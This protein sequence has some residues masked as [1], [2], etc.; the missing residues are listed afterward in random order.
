MGDPSPLSAVIL[1][2]Y[3]LKSALGLD[4]MPDAHLSDIIRLLR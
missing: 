3:F 2:L 1:I 4:L